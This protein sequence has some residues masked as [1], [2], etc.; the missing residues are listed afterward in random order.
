MANFKEVTYTQAGLS[1]GD[2][3]SLLFAEMAKYPDG[4]DTQG[5]YKIINTELAK[6]SQILSEQGKA[7]LRNLIN[8]GAVSDGFICPRD[9]ENAQSG[10]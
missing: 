3:Y 10:D 8:K 5:I 2:V 1:K 7:T 4:L 6:N 9:N